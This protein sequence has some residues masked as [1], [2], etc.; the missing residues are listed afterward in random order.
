[1]AETHRVPVSSHLDRIEQDLRLVPSSQLLLDR[2]LQQEGT[3]DEH[4]SRGRGESSA[5]VSEA[6]ATARARLA[7]EILSKVLIIRALAP[8]VRGFTLAWPSPLVVAQE[9]RP[10]HPP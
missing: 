5:P 4:G 7:R 1:M 3:T 9:Y 10:D 6:A 2:V 8:A